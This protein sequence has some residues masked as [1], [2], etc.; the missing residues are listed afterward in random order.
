MERGKGFDEENF[1]YPSLPKYVYYGVGQL[2]YRLGYTKVEFIE[3]ARL[4]SIILG[5]LV[6]A[7]TY[8]LTRLMGGGVFASTLAA[9]LVISSRDMALYSRFAHNDLFLVFFIYLCVLFLINYRIKNHR[10]WLYCAFLAVGLAASSKYNGGSMLL[11]VLAVFLISNRRLLST[12]PFAF[13]ETLFIGIILS[14]VGYAVGTPKSLTW[15]AFYFKRATPYILRHAVYGRDAETLIGLFGQWGVLWS[16]LGIGVSLL[17]L[18]AILWHGRRIYQL[19]SKK[20]PGENRQPELISILLLSMLALDLPIAI[21]YNYPPRFFLV[22]I[23]CIAILVGLFVE[24]MF[25]YFKP[26][27]YTTIKILAVVALI[28]VFAYSFLRVISVGFLFLNDSRIAASEFV[29][30]LREGSTLE[31]TLYPPSIPEDFFSEQIRHPLYAKK[32][33]NQPPP[34]RDPSQYNRGEAGVEE[35][36]PDYFI[37]DS[38]TYERLDQEEECLNMQA[39]C[40][41]FRRLLAGETNYQL[42]RRFDY[43]IPAYLP[44]KSAPFLNPVIQ[45]Y[46]RKGTS[47][48]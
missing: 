37:V 3:A 46:Q 47:T 44:E 38:F 45:I 18:G 14:V 2:V 8:Q 41:F 13:G 48:P 43:T 32:Y 42:L 9:L 11:A 17:F 33:P 39:E 24:A 22:F 4:V 23:P 16:M 19:L 6:V 31:Y 15:M 10:I 35:R 36:E 40:E 5:G 27:G 29:K 20:S 7:L 28:A 12:N 30:T 34:E 25:L 21:S 26:G 1:D